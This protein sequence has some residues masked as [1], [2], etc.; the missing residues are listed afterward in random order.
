MP[1][2]KARPIRP[3]TN[4]LFTFC[5]L[6]S[7]RA[8]YS[9]K[10]TSFSSTVKTP[11][12]SFPLSL[13]SSL[14]CAREKEI[15][16]KCGFD[17]LYK[18]QLLQDRSKQFVFHDGPPYA[19]GQPHVGH[20]LN[21]ILK[22]ITNRYK[23]LRGYKVRY[24]PG[25][26]CHGTPIEQ[27]ALAA[28]QQQDKLNP[29]EIRKIAREYSENASGLQ[30]DAFK[31]WAVMA[32]WQNGCYF[33]TDPKYEALQLEAFYQ[34]YEQGL[35]YQEYMPIFWS[36]SS[37][38][39][40]AE[41]EIVYRDDHISTQVYIKFQIN[42]FPHAL[43]NHK[44]ALDKVYAVVWTTTPWT[45]PFN[46]AICYGEGVRYCCLRSDRGELFVVGNKFQQRL[47]EILNG[48]K[49]QLVSEFMGSDLNSL[50][51]ISTNQNVC[52]FLPANHV[53]SDKGTGLVHT[54][55]AHGVE[56]FQVALKFNLPMD[57]HVDDDGKYMGD[58]DCSYKHLQGLPVLG[59]GNQQVLKDYEDM[60]INKSMLTHSYPYDWR[61]KQPIII[62]ASKQ[63]FINTN[64]IKQKAIDA[65]QD[66]C[67]HPNMSAAGMIAQLERRDYWCIS[68]Q[69]VWGV[70]IP[71]FYWGKDKKPLISRASI[72]HL[73]S[74]FEK[75]GSDCWWEMSTDQLLPKHVI[76]PDGLEGGC[77]SLEKGKDILDIWFD[78]GV[79][80]F[81]VL[82]GTS[83]YSLIIVILN[84]D[85]CDGMKVQVADVYMEGLD[86]FGGWFMSSLLTSMA[87]QQRP[88]FKK[89]VV[90]GFVLDENGRKMSK[91]L[92]N[93]VD[94]QVVVD[95]GQN[96]PAYGVDVMRLWAAH[97]GLDV[98]VS[99]GPNTLADHHQRLF[100]L[101][102]SLRYLV[103][104]LYDYKVS[105]MMNVVVDL[106]QLKQ[107]HANDRYMLHLLHDL[108]LQ[109]TAAYEEFNFS[110]V[111]RLIDW[112]TSS[113]LSAFYC[114]FIK[115]RLYC[116]DEI[117]RSSCQRTM[118][119]TLYSLTLLL[120]PI[121][122][123]FA[124]ELFMYH[125]LDKVNSSVF[126]TSDWITP[127]WSDQSLAKHYDV[128]LSIREGLFQMLG[129]D[130]PGDFVLEISTN[131]HALDSLKVIN[132]SHAG[133]SYTSPLAELM[134]TADVH[135][136]S[137][138]SNH[139]AESD[140]ES[141]L[142][143]HKHQVFHVN[144]TS[145]EL[146]LKKP[147]MKK[148][149]RCRRLTSDGHHQAGLCLRCS[150]LLSI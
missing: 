37:K 2:S 128:V 22:D 115:D 93:V 149:S 145:F 59:E 1:I 101:R 42:N 148:C 63:W 81:A 110:R 92:G 53:T 69:R 114:H 4:L 126:K 12:T 78:S 79:S 98:A 133:P 27:K 19:N 17:G 112:F 24:V 137:L 116:G 33:T 28:I 44:C 58:A 140:H 21:K 141:L 85:C 144:D 97:S 105:S 83:F 72:E 111:V 23:L 60:I 51:Y 127:L 143:M 130:K 54:A 66:V 45:L 10:K 57:C 64:K 16:K 46:K 135:L 61:T 26:D 43:L 6:R 15:Q 11:K 121:L 99:M 136:K 123:H 88:P 13:E 120:A 41:S 20:A 40:L 49:L 146:T 35:V 75:H 55:P 102:K 117:G 125:P 7:C 86:Q 25:W 31:R 94:P 3:I 132:S 150:S 50:T 96:T 47:E 82:Q 32:D 139:P 74:L 90:H 122:P 73:K 142:K 107:L 36:P 119:T 62:K 147:A 108:V 5:S 70:P 100:K 77:S 134:L 118:M 8:L 124:E 95:G 109:V 34:L 113:Q 52:P 29:L 84:Y 48:N 65:M 38:S 89:L 129:T 138:S 106:N 131:S 14:I 9:T 71:V 68:R 87:I 76:S 18:W 67:I 104:S 80:W 91:S 39:A 30:R 103:G 56:D